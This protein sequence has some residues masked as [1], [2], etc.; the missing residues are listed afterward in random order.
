[1]S[2]KPRIRLPKEA[3]KGEIIQVKTLFTH[4]MESGQRKEADGK[5]I[6][7]KIINK[8]TAEFNGK[9][10]FTCKMETGMAANPFIE[11]RTRIDEAGKFT[12]SWVDDDGTVVKAEESIAL[13]G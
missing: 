8:F 10:V 12:F 7:R 4:P 3:Q 2:E 5:T 13:K 1:M 9:P 6:P 11:F